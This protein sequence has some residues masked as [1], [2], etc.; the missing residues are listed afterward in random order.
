M[1]DPASQSASQPACTH[2]ARSVILRR[3][4]IR[5]ACSI[6]N[7]H[8]H[9]SNCKICD[10]IHP[11]M[12]QLYGGSSQPVSQPASLHTPSQISD[13]ET[14]EHQI[15][16][17]HL[18]FTYASNQSIKVYWNHNVIHV[19]I[20]FSASCHMHPSN[21]KICDRIHPI[22]LFTGGRQPAAWPRPP[23]TRCPPL[24]RGG[25]PRQKGVSGNPLRQYRPTVPLP[26]SRAKAE[27]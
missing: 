10:R 3:Q 24:S 27:E 4:S 1:V 8:M 2:P 25:H 7:S 13:F 15:C 19:T 20:S 17:Q 6:S 11:C 21:C 18:E 16:M 9:P 26:R 5:Y 22:A 23:G 14:P 12:I